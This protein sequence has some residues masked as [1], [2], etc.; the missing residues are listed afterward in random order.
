MRAMARNPED[1]QNFREVHLVSPVRG[2]APADADGE[3]SGFCA[4]HRA[5]DAAPIDVASRRWE[6]LEFAWAAVVVQAKHLPFASLA[7][8]TSYFPRRVGGVSR[9]T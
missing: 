6:C 4:R 5:G 1:C 8:R 9:R 7:V 3:V 2:I